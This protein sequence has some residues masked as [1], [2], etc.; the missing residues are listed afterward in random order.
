[1]P[2]YCSVR[3]NPP[4]DDKNCNW[5]VLF[6]FS[7]FSKPTYIGVGAP[8]SSSLLFS[9]PFHITALL[10]L[11]EH[12]SIPDCSCLTI[13]TLLVLSTISL[14]HIR[15]T[16]PLALTALSYLRPQI[17]KRPFLSQVILT[18]HRAAKHPKTCI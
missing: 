13:M 18:N 1:M 10:P 8:T 16:L 17:Y 14:L 9:P 11:S 2:S 15:A 3:T 5:L 7:Y 4:W 6:N 12:P